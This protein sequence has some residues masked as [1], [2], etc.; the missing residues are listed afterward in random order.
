LGVLLPK[1]TTVVIQDDTYSK[2]V[3]ESIQ[4][5]GNARAISKVIDAMVME[6]KDAKKQAE[7]DIVRL[8]HSKKVAKV[9]QKELERDR[10]ELSKSFEN[11][12]S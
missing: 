10:Y 12:G 4:R 5:F 1:R 8:L 6:S 11:R 7:K 3:Q 2:L 9:T